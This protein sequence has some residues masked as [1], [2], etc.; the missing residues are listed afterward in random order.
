[1]LLAGELEDRDYYREVNVF[2]VPEAA[3]WEALRAAA[4]Q[5]DIGKR[6]DD[7]LSL[8]ELENPKCR[9][10]SNIDPPCRSNTDPGMDAGRVTASCG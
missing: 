7:A 9:R 4:K 10:R 2:W 6:I 3:R 5:P 1:M 8:I